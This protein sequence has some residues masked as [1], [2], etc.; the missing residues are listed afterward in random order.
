MKRK[1]HPGEFKKNSVQKVL[2][3]KLKTAYYKFLR[4]S[5]YCTAPIP[6]EKIWPLGKTILKFC[7]NTNKA[8]ELKYI[9][10]LLTQNEITVILNKYS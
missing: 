8:F 5:N 6:Y 3:M 2:K 7:S 1:R 10:R 9:L 4:L